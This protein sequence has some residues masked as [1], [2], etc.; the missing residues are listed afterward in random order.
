MNEP[1]P[2][3]LVELAS[4][5]D[6]RLLPW[7]D[8][9]ESAFP[10][11]ER[12][13]V[14]TLLG[15]LKD[16]ETGGASGAHLLAALDP[17]GDLAGMAI[18]HELAEERVAFL[19]YLAVQPALRSGGMGAQIYRSILERLPRDFV[20]LIFDVE[21]PEH[22]SDPAA[23][24]LAR[25]RIGFYRRLGAR[26]LGGIRYRQQ[27]ADWHDPVPLHLMI[28]PLQPLTARQAFD[29]ARRIFSE[30]VVLQTGELVFE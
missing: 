18:Y 16:K 23:Q 7:L 5:S 21:I 12:V 20:M 2:I 4:R 27:A 10:P 1:P 13:A 24:A 29:L 15:Y 3:T 22:L 28:H 19:W 30:E 8:L 11:E 17:A 14:S 26:V 6:D 25:R 9:Y